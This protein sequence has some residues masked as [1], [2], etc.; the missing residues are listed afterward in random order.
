MFVFPDTTF[1][2]PFTP[3][4][5]RPNPFKPPLNIL[6]L[7]S[8]PA[9]LGDSDSDDQ[10]D[11]HA[12]ST[13]GKHRNSSASPSRRRA[14]DG[15]RPGPSSVLAATVVNSSVSFVRHTKLERFEDD[16][17]PALS[18]PID[19][20]RATPQPRQPRRPSPHVLVDRYAARLLSDGEVRRISAALHGIAAAR[21]T[22]IKNRQVP[23]WAND[24][25]QAISRTERTGM[26]R[27]R[28]LSRHIRTREPPRGTAAHSL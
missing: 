16:P 2:R 22:A 28:I 19:W 18:L 17:P 20:A 5:Y 13:S 25:P 6:D 12:R 27:S 15:A 10:P 14:G 21:Q 24:A 26:D 8:A 23:G 11:P 4:R 9:S 7:P 3:H 1:H